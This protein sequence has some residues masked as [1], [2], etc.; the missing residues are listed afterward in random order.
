MLNVNDEHF[1]DWNIIKIPEKLPKNNNFNITIS[2]RDERGQLLPAR[3]FFSK[4][5]CSKLKS[6]FSNLFRVAGL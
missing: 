3:H 2:V 5:D 4:F 6:N 1:T